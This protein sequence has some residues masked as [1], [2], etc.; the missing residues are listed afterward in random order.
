MKKILG[1]VL[2]MLTAVVIAVGVWQP[3]NNTYAPGVVPSAELT[4]V[5]AVIGS[6]KKEFFNDPEVQAVFASHGLVVDV[7]TAGSREIASLPDLQ[8]YD[9]AFPSSAPAAEKIS[10]NTGVTTNYSPFYSPMVVA[11]WEPV[12]ELL[13]SNGAAYQTA[14][15]VWVLDMETYVGLVENK[16]RWQDLTG[17]EALYNSPRSVLITSTDIRKS[18]SAAM[19][20]AIAAY[21]LNGDQV[22]TSPE[23][24]NTVLPELTG[25]FL[26][27]GFSGSS[28]EEPFHDYLTQGMGTSPMVMVYEAQYVG[29]ALK[30]GLPANA[31]VAY[32]SPTVFSKHVVIPFTENGNIVGELLETDEQLQKLA[33]AH[34]FR[35]DGA[36]FTETIMN[37]QVVGVNPDLVDVAETPNYDVIETLITRISEA[38]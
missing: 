12:M 27:Q 7:D 18:N 2:I 19:Y 6:E 26:N 17:A 37:G 15:G 21:V 28:S 30:G 10:Q 22:V 23:Q 4:H 31:T 35:T 24:E 29:E 36:S 16:T 25:L 38:Y 8:S 13:E 11:T 32:P 3:W 5:T 1:A 20:M 33:A 9:F 34:G 14:E